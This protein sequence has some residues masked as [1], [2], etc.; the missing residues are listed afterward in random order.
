M[1]SRE[2]VRR[3]LT[4]KH[5]DRAPRDLWHLPGISM[6]RRD[7]LDAMR[8]LFPSDFGGVDVTFSRSERARGTPAVVGTYVDDWGCG[9]SVAEPGVVGEVK[10]PPL[11]NWSALDHWCPPYEVLDG[12]DFSRVNASY[13]SSDKFVTGGGGNPWERMQFLRGTE[14]L[15]M[16]LAWGVA[17][18]YRLR[19]MVHEF[20]LR[21]LEMWVKTD[22]DAIGLGDDWGTQR[23]L[24]ISPR[25]WREFYKPLYAEYCRI[26]HGAGKFVFFHSDGHIMEI[27]PDLI[28]VGV[29]AVNSQLFCM[30]IEE[31][32]RRFKG[33]VTFWGEID[34][35]NV[36]P[37][38]TVAA[39]RAAVRRVRLALDDGRGGVI[40]QC[41]WG[42]GVKAENVA[43]VF[44]AWEEELSGSPLTGRDFGLVS[45]VRRI[46]DDTRFSLS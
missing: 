21:G 7:E 26:T 36:L 27:Y 29:N 4:F 23:G 38:G 10:Y 31:I 33:Q 6:Y 5:P 30:D 41:E 1:H 45:G 37:F 34:R 2:R 25:L 12:A 44:E 28:E 42:I 15:M 19:D 46:P 16:D 40:A 39:V 17:E 9:W 43:A 3:A 18:V 13:A 20:F 22:V 35:Q 11:A 14:N 24:L 32:G 8:K